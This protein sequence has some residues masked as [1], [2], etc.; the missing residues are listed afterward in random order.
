MYD[1]SSNHAL[2]THKFTGKER[3]AERGLDN[4]GARF[5]A[6]TMG[7]FMSADPFIPFNLKKGKFQAWISKA[8]RCQCAAEGRRWG[9]NYKRKRRAGQAY[10]GV[11]TGAR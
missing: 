1:C 3:D 6:S 11:G 9:E 7:R 8:N 5:N 2:F 4:F 10:S